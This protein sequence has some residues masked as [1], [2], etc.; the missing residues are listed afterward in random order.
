ML[1]ERQQG[2]QQ[3]D[4]VRHAAPL[5]IAV[6]ELHGVAHLNKWIYV[7]EAL[8]DSIHGAYSPWCIV[9]ASR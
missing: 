6:W 9:F 3:H 2:M 7:E 1:R 8:S 5:G 4:L